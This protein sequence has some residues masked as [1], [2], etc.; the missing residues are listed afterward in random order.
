[1]PTLSGNTITNAV[2]DLGIEQFLEF[3]GDVLNADSLDLGVILLS[4]RYAMLADGL[5]VAQAK[6]AI[7]TRA[8]ALSYI[9]ASSEYLAL[10]VAVRPFINAQLLAIAEL[11]SFMLTV[12]VKLVKQN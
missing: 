3:A 11:Q 8:E 5:T 6:A 10:P 4:R 1:M 2:E 7:S 12:M 9:T